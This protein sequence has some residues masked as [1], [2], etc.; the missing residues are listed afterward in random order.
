MNRLLLALCTSTFAL[1]L[2]SV[3]A[4]DE[5]PPDYTQSEQAKYKQEADTKK[6]A[7]AKMTPEQKA[8]ATK[9]RRAKAQKDQD[10]MVN[11]SQNPQGRNAGILKS[12]ETSKAGPTP[13]RGTINT[14][15]AEKLLM[16]NK[17][18]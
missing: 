7:M 3:Y 4:D 18:Q 13:P 16:K 6:A 17:G 15:E 14:P 9:A 12:A 1:G 5:T 11:A 8:A 10:A 2:S